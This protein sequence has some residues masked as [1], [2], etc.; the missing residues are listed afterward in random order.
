M[1][2]LREHLSFLQPMGPLPMGIRP[3]FLSAT[4]VCVDAVGA[5][6]PRSSL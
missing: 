2:F 5:L 3:Y 1:V 6:A 4:E